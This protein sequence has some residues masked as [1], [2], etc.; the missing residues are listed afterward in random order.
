[1]LMHRQCVEIFHLIFLRQLA[2]G[3]DRT[4]FT[5]KG[6]CN[7]RF[8]FHSIRYSEDLDLDVTTISTNT[9]KNKV[10]R[11]LA[12]PA[13]AVPLK[14]KGITVVSTSA[15]KQT[16]T[17]QRWKVG[18]AVVGQSMVIPTKV[19]FSRREGESHDPMVEPIDAGLCR[20]YGLT[21]PVIQHHSGPVALMQKVRALAGRPETQARDL[22]D[23]HLLRSQ[24]PSLPKLGLEWRAV[25]DKASE[26]ALA[27]TYDDYLSQVVAYLEPG[28]GA[29]FTDRSVW[30]AMQLEVLELL[31]ELAA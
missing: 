26:R 3:Q 14:A 7:L 16:D 1:M 15:P 10:D 2:M 25:R 9:L 13:F 5:V 4:R 24:I 28:Q 17:T 19:E 20:S 23:L 18:L 27:L 12:S 11:L 21:A 31:Q 8:F 6:G 22:F 30:E 29:A